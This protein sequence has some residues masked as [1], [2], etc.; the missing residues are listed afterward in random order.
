L[1]AHGHFYA[2]SVVVGLGL[3]AFFLLNND[4]GPGWAWRGLPLDDAWIHMVY[5]R[6]LT[7]EGWFYYNPGVPEAG[8]SSPLWVI[9][10]ALPLKLVTSPALAA[11]SLSIF[12]GLL[13]SVLAYH[14]MLDL[15]DRRELAWGAGLVT[16]LLPNFAYARVSGKEVTLV[17]SLIL[18]SS[19]F[20]LQRRYTAYGLVIGLSVIARGETAILG[21]LFGGAV[22]LR[23]YLNR[24]HLTVVTGEEF[25]LG[26]RLFLP[27]LI[28]GGL[29]AIYN[30]TISAQLLPNTYY[31][32]HNFD[33]GL[34]NPQNM[35][36]LWLGYFRNSLL[37]WEWLAIPFLGVSALGAW[38]L[39]RR[40]GMWVLP[41]LTGPWLIAYALSTN[42]AV[43]S[44]EWNF[45]ARRY[46]D[47]ILP[48]MIFPLLLG[49]AD[50]WE[51]AGARSNR[52]V[53]LGAPLALAAT[54][55]VYLGLAVVRL[56]TLAAEY[57]WNARNIEETS[58]AMGRW[59]ADHLPPDAEVGVTDAGAMR[60]FGGRHTI[61][62]LGLNHHETL[63]RPLHELLREY[64]PDYAILFRGPEIDSW[65]F[66]SEIYYIE[67]ERNTTLGGGD[68]VVYQYLGDQ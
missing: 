68:L 51:R 40:H 47:Y 55:L 28:T 31:V 49:L 30:H 50:L 54:G 15:T 37:S 26:I 52:L 24:D 43:N 19:W 60:F 58:V 62:F 44:L 17:G 23:K 48:L 6:S 16:A 34:I 67:P 9:L 64:E 59:I 39:Y 32:K 7:E 13:A 2:V 33:L 12:F 42:V 10:L 46:L 65:P 14:V 21:I 36:N 1:R 4:A 57:S 8:M 5:A 18:L 41:I 27:A 25:S 53:I 3:S 38:R 29:W 20:Y 11:K 35:A 61:D 22:L 45:T 63:G 66:L 56:N